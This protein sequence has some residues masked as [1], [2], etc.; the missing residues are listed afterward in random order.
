MRFKN[1]KI[2]FLQRILM[3]FAYLIYF[4][5]LYLKRRVLSVDF[6]NKISFY[7]GALY[8]IFLIV[9]FILTNYNF[10]INRPIKKYLNYFIIIYFIDV[11]SVLLFTL[12]VFL[13]L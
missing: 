8:F 11:F 6:F 4:L 2:Y 13:S 10:K 5:A 1:S 12:L 7:F 9:L 3:S